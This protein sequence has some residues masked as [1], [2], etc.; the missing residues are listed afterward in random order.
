MLPNGVRATEVATS[1]ARLHVLIAGEKNKPTLLLVHGNV[2]SARFFAETMAE[3]AAD[4][5]CVAPDLRG[6]GGSQR[7][8]VDARRGLADFSDDL[9]A[10][11]TETDLVPA[12]RKVTMLGWSLGGGVAMRY[13]MDH[14]DR[15]AGIVLESPASPYGFGGTKDIDGT[16]CWPDHAGSGG[17]TANPAMIERIVAGDRTDETG[18]SPRKII[19]T[20]YGN[21]PFEIAPQ[22]LDE[23]VDGILELAIGEDNYP[24]DS[25]ASPNWPNTAPGERGVNN[26]LSPKYC[27][28]SGFAAIAEQPPVLWIRGDADQIVSDFAAVDL[29]ALGQ[30]GVV[31]G[32]PGAEVFPPQ[33]MVSQTRAVLDRYAAGGGRYREVVLP[34]CGHSPHLE[35]PAEFHAAL[36]EFSSGML[37]G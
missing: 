13:A 29:G 12:G 8:P 30:L 28:L 26:A 34:G 21:P 23:Y 24:G 35:R 37:I 14:A 7:L 32:W 19:T 22:A 16:P 11:L 17:G 5:H 18:V 10:L 6:F 2:S 36:A 15:L 20:L 1:R 25:V 3:L 9:H 31:P 33:P 4:W 27:D